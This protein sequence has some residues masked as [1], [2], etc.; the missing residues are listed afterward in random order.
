[1][2]KS[3]AES[4]ANL[5]Y[6]IADTEASRLQRRCNPDRTETREC[7][8]RMRGTMLWRTDCTVRSPDSLCDRRRSVTSGN[9]SS[10]QDSS[11]V[12][13]RSSASVGSEKHCSDSSNPDCCS[14]SLALQLFRGYQLNHYAALQL[15]NAIREC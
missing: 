13:Q 7:D 11:V 6:V 10:L 5:T 8:D 2:G 4:R 15:L 14:G 3:C 12:V 1:M 9:P